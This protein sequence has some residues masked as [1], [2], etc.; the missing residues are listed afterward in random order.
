M[1]VIEYVDGTTVLEGRFFEAQIDG[2]KPCV[3]LGHSWDG[4]NNRVFEIGS[5]L[6]SKGLN[7]FSI[8]VYGKGIRGELA[9][10]NS[11]LMNPLLENRQLLHNRI[12]RGLEKV[13][14]IESVDKQKIYAL[15]FC[16]GGLCVLDL[17][18]LNPQ[19]LKK[20]IAVHSILS[21]PSN[22]TMP[23]KIDSEV[24]LLHGWEDPVAKPQDLMMFCKEMESKQANWSAHV[25]GNTKHA[26]TLEGANIPE[27][28]VQYNEV[29]A[30]KAWEAIYSCL[31]IK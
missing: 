14:E 23:K 3:L 7:A 2:P 31:E 19:G 6:A 24:L 21:E 12:L 8:D 26:F 28:G 9:G 10:D 29:S 27:L 13:R 22:C 17:A 4:P 25:Y 30:K 20:V 16:F 18:R 1:K 11:H 5:E 15:G